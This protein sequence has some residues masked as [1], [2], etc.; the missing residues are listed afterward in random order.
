M[1]FQNY[2]R[3][4][5]EEKNILSRWF[6]LQGPQLLCVSNKKAPV[7]KME[8]ERKKKKKTEQLNFVEVV[9]EKT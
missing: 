2:G 1:K 3:E 9:P 6:L 4:R 7:K 8:K 5:K